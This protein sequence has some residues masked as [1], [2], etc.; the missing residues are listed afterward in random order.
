[1][2]ERAGAPGR[3]GMFV[4]LGAVALAVGLL[5]PVALADARAGASAPAAVEE[6]IPPLPEPEKQWPDAVI[7]GDSYTEGAGS[8]T[9][10]RERRWSTL[11][12]DAME[13]DEVNLSVPGTGYAAGGAERRSFEFLIDEIVARSPDVVLVSGG[14][15]DT[16]FAATDV[17]AAATRLFARLAEDV[18][19]A[20]VIVISPWWDDD[21]APTTFDEAVDAI[22]VAAQT[23]GV[24][25]LD[26]GQP[27]SGRAELLSPDGVHPNDD[28]HAALADAVLTALRTP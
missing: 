20:E 23:A 15:N 11:M 26:T 8:S 13:W 25:Y 10:S 9:T 12:S 16:W 18:P 2:S 3:T 27:L 4:A 28:G 22:R 6:S 24:R 7:L 21:A 14:R 1:M 19:D 17:G 5:V